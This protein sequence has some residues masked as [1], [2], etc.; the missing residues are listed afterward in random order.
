MTAPATKVKI[1]TNRANLLTAGAVLC[2]AVGVVVAGL[3]IV[4]VMAAVSL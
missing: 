3:S 4:V 1:A 2:A